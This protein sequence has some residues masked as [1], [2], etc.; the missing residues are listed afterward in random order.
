VADFGVTMAILAASD[1]KT[2]T[3]SLAPVTTG[4]ASFGEFWARVSFPVL[5]AELD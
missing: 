1:P 5:S 4:A 3:Y 2:S